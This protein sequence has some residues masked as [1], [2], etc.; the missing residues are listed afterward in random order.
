MIE[1]I[2]ALLHVED[3]HAVSTEIHPFPSNVV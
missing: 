3:P 2:A 1:A